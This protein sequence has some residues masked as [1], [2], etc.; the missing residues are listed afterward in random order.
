MYQTAFR[1]LFTPLHLW[2]VSCFV[3]D[4]LFPGEHRPSENRWFDRDCTFLGNLTSMGAY[5]SF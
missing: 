2:M 5:I 1:A 4:L 3:S